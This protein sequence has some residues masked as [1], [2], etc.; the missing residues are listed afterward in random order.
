MYGLIRN[1]VPGRHRHEMT[2]TLVLDRV[3]INFG[4]CFNTR[5]TNSSDGSGILFLGQSL[6]TFKGP[7]KLEVD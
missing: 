7:H 4:Q 1:H 3:S 6:E 5:Y 2:A